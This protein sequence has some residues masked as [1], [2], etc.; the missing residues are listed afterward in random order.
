LLKRNNKDLFPN[1]IVK[2]TVLMI[3]DL[4]IFSQLKLL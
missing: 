4:V 1:Q 2:L 3:R